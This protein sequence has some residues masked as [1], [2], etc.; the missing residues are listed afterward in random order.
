MGV[1]V[2]FEAVFKDIENYITKNFEMSDG[3][4]ILVNT[5][6]PEDLLEEKILNIQLTKLIFMYKFG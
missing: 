1:I 6:S 4:F 3:T 5:L 2:S